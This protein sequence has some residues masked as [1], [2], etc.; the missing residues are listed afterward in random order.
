MFFTFTDKMNGSSNVEILPVEKPAETKKDS[1][2]E[3]NDTA[4]AIGN[5]KSDAEKLVGVASTINVDEKQISCEGEPKA[6]IADMQYDTKC[7]PST[8]SDKKS[9]ETEDL[10]EGSKKRSVRLAETSI[11]LT[12]TGDE[13]QVPTKQADGG[14]KPPRRERRKL[15]PKPG[16]ET[17][18]PEQCVQQ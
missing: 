2:V 17:V 16:K 9:D 3:T 6:C 15:V 14:N 18:D 10:N 5:N 8:S 7:S 4:S 1:L 11:A 13:S 12:S